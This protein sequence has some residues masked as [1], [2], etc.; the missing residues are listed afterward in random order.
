MGINGRTM[1]L[2]EKG[3]NHLNMELYLVDLNKKKLRLG[4]GVNN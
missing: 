2:F 1:E 4:E 3:I